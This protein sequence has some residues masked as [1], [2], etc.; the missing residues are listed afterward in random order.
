MLLHGGVTARI[1]E[2]T[3]RL[4]ATIAWEQ[5]FTVGFGSTKSPSRQ[6]RA[7]PIPL[8]D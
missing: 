1:V 8:V 4:C 6:E 3:V 7:T 5:W 2:C